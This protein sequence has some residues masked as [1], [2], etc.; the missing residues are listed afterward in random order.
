MPLLDPCAA[1]LPVSPKQQL[2]S[3]PADALDAELHALAQPMASLQCR[4]EI[5]LLLNDVNSAREALREGLLEVKRL[6]ASID[7]MRALVLEAA[8]RERWAD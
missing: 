8:D 6:T 4:L 1:K 5:G 7:R 2:P 3:L